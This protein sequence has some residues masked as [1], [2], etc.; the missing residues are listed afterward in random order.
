MKGPEAPFHPSLEWLFA[1]QRF[2]MRT[3]LATMRELLSRL[4]SPEAGFRSVLVAGTNGKGSVARLLAA[5]LQRSGARTGL[6]TSPHLQRVGE[7]AMVDG[8]SATDEEMERAVRAVREHA[9]AVEAT[10]FEALT[11]ACLLHFAEAGVEMAVLEVG[12]GG[13]LDATNV[14]SPGLSIVTGV[15][16]DHTAVLGNTL[17]EIAREKAGVL[18]EGVPLVTGAT[19]VALE[20]LEESA[21]E[22]GAPAHVLGREF[23]VNDVDASWEG[24]SFTLSWRGTAFP[25]GPRPPAPGSARLSVPLVGAHQAANAALAAYGALLLGMPMG[26]VGE[27]LAVTT[28]PGRMERWRHAGRYV[29]LDGAHNPQSAGALARA[30][31]GLPGRVAALVVGVSSDKDVP[32]ILRELGGVAPLTLFTR[33]VRSPRSAEPS[34]LQAVWQAEGLPGANAVAD[35]PGAALRRALAVCAED[36]LV[37]VAGSLFLVAEVRDLL[38]GAEPEPYDRWQ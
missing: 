38:A 30:L 18:R 36:E 34:E 37:V 28:W 10:F 19:G 4:G 16:L 7:R 9:V 5:A 23:E 26:E 35:E 6:F 21:A 24:T 22:L 12:L 2:G 1:L 3:G 27:A 33:A 13:R 14:V 17:G 20:V 15:A 32:A 29:L 8:V 11:A 31:S 25:E